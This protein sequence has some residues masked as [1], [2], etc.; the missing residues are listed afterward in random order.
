MLNGEYI[1]MISLLSKQELNIFNRRGHQY[2]LAV[3]EKDYFLAIV[4]KMIYDSPLRD[5]LIFKGGTAIHHCYLPQ[6]RFSE[7]LDFTALDKNITL[8]EVRDVL[9][10]QEFIIIKKEYKS[11]ATIKF[12]RVQ[13]VG[14]LGLPNYLKVEIDF[15]QNVVL[16]ARP[17][18]YKNVWGVQ[19]PAVVM[20]I[21]EICAEKIRA[22]NERAKYRDFYDLFLI[23]SQYHLSLVEITGLIRQK[24]MRQPITKPSICDKWVKAL[25]EKS[26]ESAQIH[27]SKPIED[28]IIKSFIDT[29]P[30][31]E[32][33]PLPY[34]II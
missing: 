1:T 28:N 12:E 27:Y 29:L 2:A 4:S 18:E 11:N 20:D 9:Q 3:A 10:S 5:K 22:C 17:I 34:G 13:Y 32:I 24:E 26:K 6:Y 19:T 31:E 21:R 30:F 25:E 33:L 15:I 7:D 16:P 8:E 23:C 14:P